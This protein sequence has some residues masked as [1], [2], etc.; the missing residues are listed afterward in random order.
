MVRILVTPERLNDLSRQMSQ[1]AAQLRDIDSQLG[2]T[3]NGLNWE[4]RQQIKIEGQVQ[5]ARQQ[6]RQMAE[7]ADVLARY[8]SERATA[9][10]QAD[11][12]SSAE[13]DASIQRFRAPVPGPTPVPIPTSSKGD[14]L[15]LD[16]SIHSLDDLLKPIDWISDSKKATRAFDKTL[17]EAGRMFNSLTGQRGHI[18]LMGQFGD[19]LRDASKGAGF[20]GNVLDLKDMNLYFSGQLTNAEIADVALKVLVPIPI[21]NDRFANWAIQNMSDPSGHWRGLVTTVE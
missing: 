21:I 17:E 16:D 19:F 1:G 2:R 10:E 4:V 15:S 18:K 7:Q 3:L 6:A 8:L 12:R 5:S 14:S 9:F 11:S 13:W 20:L